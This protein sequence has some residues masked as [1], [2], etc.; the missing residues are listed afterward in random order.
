MTNLLLILIA[1]MLEVCGDASI[2]IGLRGHKT[3]SFLIGAALV[4]CYGMVISLPNWSFGRT[5]GIYI[6]VFLIVSQIVAR[7]MLHENLRLPTVVGG[8]LI[9]SGGLVI[10]IWRPA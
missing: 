10:L 2:R 1:I 9:I 8:L 4:V 3:G 5:M 6:S 7:W